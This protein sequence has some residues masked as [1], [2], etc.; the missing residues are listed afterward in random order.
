MKNIK[1]FEEFSLNEGLSGNEIEAIEKFV[2]DWIED[3]AMGDDKP[4]EEMGDEELQGIAD[5]F[6]EQ[7][8]DENVWDG[9]VKKSNMGH[10]LEFACQYITNSNS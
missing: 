7:N 2:D 8:N 9:I 4:L 6:R 5:T 1:L 10:A 3:S